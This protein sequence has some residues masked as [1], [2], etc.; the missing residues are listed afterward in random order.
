MGPTAKRR[1]STAGDLQEEQRLAEAHTKV[2]CKDSRATHLM[3][4]LLAILQS[5]QVAKKHREL[6]PEDIQGSR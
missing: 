2:K 4:G 3:L 1:S 6:Y 5:L